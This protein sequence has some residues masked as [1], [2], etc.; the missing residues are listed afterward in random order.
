MTRTR[1]C[2]QPAPIQF[3]LSCIGNS[4]DKQ[5]CGNFN[6]PCGDQNYVRLVN[7]P[8]AFEGRLEV[9]YNGQWGTVCDDSFTNSGAR[10]VCKMLGF[11]WYNA[12]E[13]H[14]AYYGQGTLPILVDEVTC[15]G[16][17]SSI[18]E[19]SH[20]AWYKPDCHHGEDV[21]VSCRG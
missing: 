7:G 14:D 12:V 19:C 6:K 1:T 2:T 11:P 8:S 3:G 13:H 10:V 18:F 21:G 15:L 20:A 16:T 4:E 5:I 17:E 9:Y